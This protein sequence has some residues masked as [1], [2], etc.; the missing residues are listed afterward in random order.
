MTER[1]IHSVE[2]FIEAVHEDSDSW[3]AEQPRWFRGEPVSEQALLPTLYRRGLAHRENALLQMFRA[4]APGFHD[5]VPHRDHTDQWLFLARHAG[6]PTRLLDWSEGALFGL[7][8]AL[9][10]G[11][12]PAVVWMLNPLQ[13]F[14]FALGQPA[15]PDPGDLREFPLPWVQRDPP[16][17]NPAFENIRGAWE[18]DEPGVPL[19]VPVY[20]TYVH[21]RLRAQRA[22]FTIHGKRKEGLNLLVPDSILKCYQVDP[23]FHPSMLN[24]LALLG[25]TDSVAFPD[26]DGLANELKNRL[27]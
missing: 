9:K 16:N 24:D 21:P 18:H 26:L 15:D 27:S 4:R 12:K 22:C 6:L 2:E 23:A 11:G 1:T 13:L 19:P 17:E 5:A 7:H 20:P 25:V 10:E 8:F 14:W 3:P